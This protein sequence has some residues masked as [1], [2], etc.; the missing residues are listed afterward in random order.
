VRLGGNVPKWQTGHLEYLLVSVAGEP[1]P[2]IPQPYARSPPVTDAC[3][4]VPAH[5]PCALACAS[6]RLTAY[7]H[8]AGMQAS[9]CYR[10]GWQ[11]LRGPTGLINP[12]HGAHAADSF[13]VWQ[14]VKS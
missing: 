13:A 6:G 10:C 12:Y 1:L 11:W 2:G 3:T 9:R 14:T 4:V 7:P 5:C 8:S